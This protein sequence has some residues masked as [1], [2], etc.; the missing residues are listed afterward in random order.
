[1]SSSYTIINEHMSMLINKKK[2]KIDCSFHFSM[3]ID[4]QLSPNNSNP[5]GSNP[6][7]F[8]SC[9]ILR[10]ISLFKLYL[11]FIKKYWLVRILK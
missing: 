8:R 4:I 5:D 9:L 2:L 10:N 7:I 11:S 3:T 1:M 6:W